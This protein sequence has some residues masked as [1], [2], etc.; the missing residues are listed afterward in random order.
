MANKLKKTTQFLSY[1]LW[2]QTKSDVTG[3]RRWAYT[4][5]KTIV[6]VVRGFISKDLNTRANALTYSLLFAIV[7]ILAAVFSEAKGFGM[8][9]VI[10][11]RLQ[12]S[13]LGNTQM[14]DTLMAFVDRYLDTAQG[15]VFVG[16]GLLVLLWAIY[17]FFRNVE[18]LF[19]N[20][21][22]VQQSRSIPR[23]L[24][25]Y[26]AIVFLIPILIIVS[27]G[28]SIFFNTAI[29]SIP[30]FGYIQAHTSTLLR[31]VQ[32]LTGAFIFTWMYISIPNTKVH[33]ISGFIPGLIVGGL[34]SLLQSLSVYVIVFLS[35]TS[36]VYGAFASIPILLTWLQW[37]CL[38]ILIGAQMSYAIENNENFEYEKDLK[39]ISRRYKDY[40]TLYILSL[41]IERFEAGEPPMSAEDISTANHLPI[42]LTNEVLG[43]L[44]KAE[45]IRSIYVEENVNKTYQPALDTHKITV[46]F[47]LDRLDADGA[48]LFLNQ[49][50]EERQQFWQTW[51]QI[52]HQDLPS[53]EILVS[54]ISKFN[55]PKK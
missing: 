17:S 46:G 6:L 45:I 8:G 44:I 47:V 50:S 21:W 18:S 9:D 33:F 51:L 30:Y 23:Q 52:K 27:S 14:V 24:T 55:S 37:T 54:Q 38:L 13:F 1:D 42:R 40:I 22:N 4:I 25:T 7:P 29:E 41:I 39:S 5:L 16:I 48:E 43:Q 53:H 34:Y 28:I 2:R 31:F 19:N 32:W 12:K 49:C 36:I 20:I 11:E 15:G 10:K 3:W 35:R 26:I